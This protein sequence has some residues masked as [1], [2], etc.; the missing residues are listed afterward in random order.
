MSVQEL[1]HWNAYFIIKAE[2]EAEAYKNARRQAQTRKV[3]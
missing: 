1:Y 3:R 2:R